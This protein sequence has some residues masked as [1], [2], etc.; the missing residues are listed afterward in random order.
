M[1]LYHKKVSS[2]NSETAYIKTTESFSISF[3]IFTTKLLVY[4]WPARK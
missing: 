3:K 1:C 2:V 4:V